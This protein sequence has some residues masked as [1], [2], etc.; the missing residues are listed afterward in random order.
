MG[1]TY[2]Y[3]RGLV[4]VVHW[5]TPVY[6]VDSFRLRHI[7]AQP[8]STAPF[9]SIMAPLFSIASTLYQDHIS[10]QGTATT[11]FVVPVLRKVRLRMSLENVIKDMPFIADDSWTYSDLM[12]NLSFGRKRKLQQIAEVT[13]TADNQNLGKS[14]C[15]DR[16]P[17][18]PNCG[19]GGVGTSVCTASLQQVYENISVQ[20]GS[21]GIP[22]FRHNNVGHEATRQTLPLHS[23]FKL[24]PAINSSAIA[25]D[26]A[27]GLPRNF[28]GDNAK[29]SLAQ[30]MIST[31][32]DTV[33]SNSAIS[34]K[35]ENPDAQLTPVAA[36]KKPKQTPV[37]LDDIQQQQQTG[38]PLV[39][40]TGTDMKW[41]N[42]LPHSQPDIKGIQHSSTWGGQRY[43]LPVMNNV[44]N[45]E[46]GA[47]FF[48]QQ[49][50]RYG[51]NEE[52]SDRQETERPKDA[53]PTLDS[54][55]SVL[56]LQQLR[57]QHLR[58]HS[59]MRNHPPTA[60]EWQ[61]GRPI[62]E[63]IVKDDVHQRRISVPS[64]L[65]P[66]GPM[67]QSPVSSKLGDISCGS[68][69]GQF[70]GV[71]TVSALGVQKGKL[72]AIT[73]ASVSSM[74]APLAANSPSTTAAPMGD[75]VILERFAKIGVVAQ[76]YVIYNL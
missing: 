59:S 70:S 38:P 12:L 60:V 6:H 66:S 72:T 41:K 64:P 3:D 5:H 16:K 63:D 2:L 40:L 74:N 53:P 36:M 68:L 22:S 37:R 14:I 67:V 20:H 57:A 39:G 58:Q 65:V 54:D 46:P 73:N 26:R 19:Q 44:P 52:H 55:N 61:N 56:D 35:R 28:S 17:G 21:S 31:Y 33:G 29:M 24:Q 10:E 76:R 48:N 50:L 15:T 25:E 75:Q 71:R 8:G 42:Q 45:N 4:R 62:T 69:A 43:T 49:G 13:V 27:S 9:L 47:P 32:A 23:E 7:G 1:S 11:S 30:N 18:N 34:L 51:A